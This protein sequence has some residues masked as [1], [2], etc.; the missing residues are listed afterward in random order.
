MAPEAAV[1]PQV[2]L[3]WREDAH[4]AGREQET[5]PAVTP[6]VPAAAQPGQEALLSSFP[7]ST[8]QIQPQGNIWK[9]VEGQHYAKNWK[10]VLCCKNGNVIKETD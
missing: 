5:R 2:S 3:A 10:G 4:R 1:H 6:K 7:G 9:E 8:A